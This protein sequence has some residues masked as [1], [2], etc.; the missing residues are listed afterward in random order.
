[1]RTSRLYRICGSILFLFWQ[2]IFLFIPIGLLLF[3]FFD[4][5]SFFLNIFWLYQSGFFSIIFRSFFYAFSVAFSC[6]VVGIFL[7]A[8]L[9][10]LKKSTQSLVLLLLFIPLAIHFFIHLGA[11]IELLSSGGILIAIIKTVFPKSMIHSLLYNNIAV[12]F[13]FFYCYFPYVIFPIYHSFSRIEKG[14]FKAASDLGASA[15]QKFF[16]IMI[17]MAR[18]GIITAFFI[19]FIPASGEFL[20]PELIG[21]DRFM[22]VGSFIYHLI[23]DMS[24]M[25]YAATTTLVYLI[26]LAIFLFIA[27]KIVNFFILIAQRV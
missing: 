25:K 4:V 7:S 2:S 20:I 24:L 27:Y 16:G 11:W 6:T 3:K 17:P 1:M 14:Y 19:V 8:S 22:H 18:G 10:T 9:L 5:K 15:M 23:S 26:F 13:V 21:G 12:F